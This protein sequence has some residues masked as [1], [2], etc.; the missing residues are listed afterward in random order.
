MEIINVTGKELHKNNACIALG[1]FDG[2]HIG[3]QSIINAAVDEARRLNLVSCVYT[4]A[5]H[6]SI[7]LGNPKP[8]IT[9]NSEKSEL[10][11]NLGV[12]TLIYDD[13]K[14]VKDLSPEEFCKEILVGSLGATQIFCGENYHFGKNG[15]GNASV[16]K[17][18][19][20]KFGVKVNV[21][22]FT[23]INNKI[24]SSTEIRAALS[25][26]NIELCNKMLGRRY[27]FSGK[28][29]HGKHLGRILGFPTLNI[30]IE[31]CKLIPKLGVYFTTT[32]I[33]DK[34]YN[35][36]SNIG[37]RP[38]T[39]A[40]DNSDVNCETY[41]LNYNDDVYNKDI[42]VNLI[43]M[44]RDEKKFNNIDELKTQLLK[45]KDIAEKYFNNVLMEKK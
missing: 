36:I 25:C 32:T 43:K 28:V 6:P 12:D 18:E 8:L 27:S 38:T 34:E 40:N 16:L 7:I 4:F 14:E 19:L 45:D 21:L 3:H 31:K 30:S 15:V 44:L 35:S 20:S 26:G 39:D 42:S 2:V 10:L 1:N 13:F 17:E 23:T 29:I 24:V 5:C 9:T 33:D 37:I 41:V 11:C 22:P